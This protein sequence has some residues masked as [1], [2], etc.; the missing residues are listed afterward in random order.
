MLNNYREIYPEYKNK[1]D[2]DVGEKILNSYCKFVLVTIKILSG[3]LKNYNELRTHE[4]DKTFR[5][6]YSGEDDI[7]AVAYGLDNE[8][9]I[10][11]DD[12]DEIKTT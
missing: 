10:P 5:I 3:M 9:Y 12:E 6:P 11:E 8:H 2:K 7:R 1:N 4:E